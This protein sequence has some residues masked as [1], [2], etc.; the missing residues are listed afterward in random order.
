MSSPRWVLILAAV[1]VGCGDAPSS[2]A[3]DATLEAA[4]AIANESCPG[5]GDGCTPVNATIEVA[6]VAMDS[7]SFTSTAGDVYFASRTTRF[8]PP[9]PILPPNPIAPTLDAWSTLVNTGAS[10]RAYL[11][12]IRALPPNP[13]APDVSIHFAVAALHDGTS[14]YLTDVTPVVGP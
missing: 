1:V 8:L 14:Y 13:V 6:S 4:P 2:V 7:G 9:S 3:T 12:L 10:Y 11:G 5:L